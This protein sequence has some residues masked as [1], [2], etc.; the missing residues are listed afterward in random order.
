MRAVMPLPATRRPSAD[1]AKPIV[2]DRVTRLPRASEVTVP[3]S[4]ARSLVS[5]LSK[6]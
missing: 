2:P 5:A 4:A 6:V 1:E 3:D